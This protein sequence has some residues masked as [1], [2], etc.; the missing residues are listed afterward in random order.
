[1]PGAEGKHSYLEGSP[2][3][4]AQIDLLERCSE[5]WDGVKM[6]GKEIRNGWISIGLRHIV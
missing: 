5:Y 3:S 1:M 2:S 6:D 4:S